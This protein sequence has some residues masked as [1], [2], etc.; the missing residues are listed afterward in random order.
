MNIATRSIALIGD[1]DGDGM[2]EVVVRDNGANRLYI[3][4]G[5]T[6]SLE[7]TINAPAFLSVANALAMAD[8]D[9][10]G[11]GEIYVTPNNQNLYCYENDGTP[12]V[13]FAINSC[14]T[15]EAA[16]GIADFNGDGTPEIYVGNRIFHSQTGV[17]L[18]SGGAGS[19]GQNLIYAWHPVA[20]DVLPTGFCTDCSGLELVCCNTVYSVDIPG[21]NLTAIPNN[22][23]GLAD[24]F[25]SVADFNGD[26]NLDIA[27]TS[28][29]TVYL[30]DPLTGNQLGATFNLSGTALGG[31]PN[32]ADYDNDGL[33]EIGAGGNSIYYVID[34]DPVTDALSTLWTQTTVDNSQMTTGSAF[35]FEGDGITEVVYRDENN[36]F[37]WD[38]AT[39]AIKAQTQCGSAT[40]TDFPTVA[41]VN[42][43]GTANIICICATTNQ[44]DPGK[45]RVYESGGFP[46]ISTREVMN[47][48]SYSITNINR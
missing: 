34:Y 17:L 29:G 13:G 43:D 11:F 19:K 32:I 39:G 41:D 7:V 10:D 20:A 28:Q 48:H 37:I 21:G 42:G 8:T 35:D 9:K 25:T 16:P 1:V 4:D 47:Q 14:G 2:P 3:L 12:K 30:W 24:G 38:G 5:V 15:S 36:L 26:G 22:L 46:W 40:R 18:A 31:R 33:P 6:G 45:V 27:V 44:G 23:S